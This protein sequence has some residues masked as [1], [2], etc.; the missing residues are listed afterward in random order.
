[1]RILTYS[2]TTKATVLSALQRPTRDFAAYRRQVAPILDAVRREGDAALLRLS[3]QFDGVEPVS[4]RVPAAEMRRALDTLPAELRQSLETAQAGI[5]RFHRQ[6][7]PAE[8]PIETRPG[9]CCWRETRAIESA[10][11]YVP[12]GTA[13]LVS[14]VLMLGIP[15]LTAGV[16]C[17]ALCTPPGKDG[18]VPDAILAAC[19]MIG[20]EDVF[21][22]GGAQ[23]IAALAYGTQTV[24]KVAKIAGPGNVYVAA[25]KA[26]V[27]VDPDGAAIDML[28]GPSELLVVADDSARPES[29]AADMLSQA[30]HDR[31]SQVVLVTTSAAMLDRVQA[32]LERQVATLPRREI[33]TA[34]LANSVAVVVESLGVAAELVNDYA[35]EHLSIQT[36][37]PEE[38]LARVRNA[39]SVFLGP[40]SPEAVGDYSSGTNH[41]LPTSGVARVQGG[42]S[43]RTFQKTLTVQ[44]LSPDGLRSLADATTALARTEGLEA[45]ARAVD[46]RLSQ[47]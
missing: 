34:A 27:S 2:P 12:G 32:E 9:V 17:I 40:F 35:P 4:I 19:A 21:A 31:Q 36:E 24:P 29:V 30:E 6:E 26:E 11:L 39:G 47:L 20:I 43:V 33:A 22:V 13:P 44:R 1:M 18:R 28:A 10:G 23:A 38:V 41:V 37:R 14:T 15:A 25:A 7:T 16:P 8:E 5:T 42:V 45:H 3:K 46:I